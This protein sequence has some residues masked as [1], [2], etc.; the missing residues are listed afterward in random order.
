MRPVMN[1]TS[2][3]PLTDMPTIAPVA[4]HQWPPL[5]D[6]APAAAGSAC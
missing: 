1:P 5:L 3:A 4:A 6:A 2:T